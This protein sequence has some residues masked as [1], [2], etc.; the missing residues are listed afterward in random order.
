MALMEPGRYYI[1]DLCY[2]LRDEKWEE[3]CNLMFPDED[4]EGKHGIFTLKDG[5]KFAIFPTMYGDGQYYDREGNTYG[6]DSG[7]IGCV[8]ADNLTIPQHGG[9][10]VRDFEYKFYPYCKNGVLVF[11]DTRIDTGDED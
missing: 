3:V 1:G 4:R 2:V 9:Y 8:L 11:D 5:T 10:I 7:T 6:V